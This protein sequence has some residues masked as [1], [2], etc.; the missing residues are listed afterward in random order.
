MG[1]WTVFV[2]LRKKYVQLWDPAVM[3]IY[4]Q[5]SQKLRNFYTSIITVRVER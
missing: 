1:G 2:W 5:V 4:L 3:V